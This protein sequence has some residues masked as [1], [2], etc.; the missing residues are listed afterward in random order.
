M[1]C[2][3]LDPV[4]AIAH[5]QRLLVMRVGHSDHGG[6]LFRLYERS[7]NML[8]ASFSCALALKLLPRLADGAHALLTDGRRVPT[9]RRDAGG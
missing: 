1:T 7:V 8:A 2:V 6:S 3:T 4:E 5:P 9:P